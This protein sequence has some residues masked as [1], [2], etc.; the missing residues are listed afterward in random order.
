MQNNPKPKL[1]VCELFLRRGG[2]TEPES[3]HQ[4]PV[5]VTSYIP[6]YVINSYI[7]FLNFFLPLCTLWDPLGRS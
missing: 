4:E 1:E 6:H 2:G 3:W 5:A 7:S